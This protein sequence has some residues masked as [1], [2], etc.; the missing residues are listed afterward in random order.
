[1]I[2]IFTHFNPKSAHALA[3]VWLRGFLVQVESNLSSDTQ[4]FLLIYIMSIYFDVVTDSQK[5][6]EFNILLSFI[7]V[8]L[9]FSSPSGSLIPLR[10]FEN[11]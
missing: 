10:N 6:L 3:R 9:V 5:Q 8:C 2:N 11:I 1:M 4:F 7:T